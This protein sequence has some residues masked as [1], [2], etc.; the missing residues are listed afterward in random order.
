M[1]YG[2]SQMFPDGKH[3]CRGIS[4][5]PLGDPKLPTTQWAVGLEWSL[6]P[7]EAE[8]YLSEDVAKA[9]FVQYGLDVDSLAIIEPHSEK[10][11]LTNQIN[12]NEHSEQ[13]RSSTSGE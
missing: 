12:T 10:E 4:K 8:K 2:I 6:K 1:Y 9:A 3:W 7:E 11:F 5:T 13:E